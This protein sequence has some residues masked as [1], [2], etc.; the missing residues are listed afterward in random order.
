[1]QHDPAGLGIG[2]LGMQFTRFATC[3]AVGTLAHYLLLV[4]LVQ[5]LG[6]SPVA[7]SSAGF[8]LG[9][10]VNYTL[11]YRYTFRSSKPHREAMWKFFLVA[12]IGA[13]INAALMSILI[14]HVNLHYLL[15]QM[16]ATGTVLVWNFTVSR[17]WTFKA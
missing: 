15:S 9:A 10:A 1:M 6:S 5:G 12:L 17:I 4:L 8:V 3:G 2:Q 7:A 13:S 16:I 11:N 14:H